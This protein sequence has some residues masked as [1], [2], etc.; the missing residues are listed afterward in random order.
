MTSNMKTT[1][2][3]KTTNKGRHPRTNAQTGQMKRYLTVNKKEDN[4][5]IEDDM[6]KTTQKTT[7]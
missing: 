3:R 5:K 7:F 4:Q 1:P 6:D 2:G